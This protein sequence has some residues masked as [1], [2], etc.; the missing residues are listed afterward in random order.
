MCICFI[1]KIFSI[2]FRIQ[3]NFVK[4]VSIFNRIVF[5]TSEN[6]PFKYLLFYHFLSF[7]HFLFQILFFFNNTH[8]SYFFP[9]YPPLDYTTVIEQTKNISF[10]KKVSSTLHQ[11]LVNK[12][13]DISN[14][15]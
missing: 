5:L 4:M 1:E 3:I 10:S 9:C 7:V 14:E 6:F 11:V 15:A 12:Y 13:F 8:L 2:T